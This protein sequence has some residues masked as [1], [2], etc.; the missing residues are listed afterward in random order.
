MENE[1]RIEDQISTDNSENQA[2]MGFVERCI[3]QPILPIVIST[4]ILLLGGFALMRLQIR[5]TP[6]VERGVFDIRVNTIN[7]M[8]AEEVEDQITKKLAKLLP[9]VPNLDYFQATS[10]SGE[11]RTT[12]HFK[13]GV[14]ESEALNDLRSVTSRAYLGSNA[15]APLIFSS[16]SDDAMMVLYFYP[17]ESEINDKNYFDNLQ[18]F[19]DNVFTSSLKK[20]DGVGNVEVFGHNKPN[21]NIELNFFK[22]SQLGIRPQEISMAINRE[23]SVST[24]ADIKTEIRSFTCTSRNRIKDVESLGEV[25]VDSKRNIKLKDVAKITIKNPEDS[26]IRLLNGKTKSIGVAI[27][28]TSEG[29]PIAI[30]KSVNHLLDN[31]VDRQKTQYVVRNSFEKSE[32]I[33]H[34]TKRT[35]VEAIILLLVILILFLG[36]VRIL[37]L[38]LVAI[39]LSV[40]GTF[41][42]MWYFNLSINEITLMAFLLTIGLL[43]DDAILIIENIERRR[44]K[45]GKLD[46]NVVYR[47]TMEIYKSVIVMTAT[48]F[49]VFLPVVFLPGEM[50]YLLREFAITISVSVGWSG[51]FS[52]ILT[53]MMCKYFMRNYHPYHW[54]ESFLEWLENSYR[55]FLLF[56][57]P[58][59]KFILTIVT[60]INMSGL[61][62]LFFINSEYYPKTKSDYFGI[63]TNGLRNMKTEYLRQIEGDKISQVVEKYLPHM[64]YYILDISGGEID[65]NG[66]FLKYQ[67]DIFGEKMKEDLQ[68]SIPYIN[69]M[70]YGSDDNNLYF[71]I[72]FSSQEES[73]VDE[74]AYEF[75]HLLNKTG[76]LKEYVF[77]QNSSYSY[78][79]EINRIKCANNRINPDDVR[80]YLDF[81][82]QSTRMTGK[83]LTKEGKRFRIV[84]KNAE[85]GDNIKTLLSYPWKVFNRRGQEQIVNLYDLVEIK[86]VVNQISV[87]TYNGLKSKRVR[88]LCEKNVTAG[89]IY[90]II[91]NLK[92]N[93]LSKEVYLDYTKDLKEYEQNSGKIIYV[94]IACLLSIFLILSVQFN[95][96]ISSAIVMLTVP[97]A[98]TGAVVILY[99]FGTINIFSMIGGI[100]LIAL[101][102][103]HGI[104]FMSKKG[105]VIALSVERLRPLLMTT[106]A[107]ILGSVPLLLYKEEAMVPLKQMAIVIVPGLFYGTLMVLVVFPI[108]LFLRRSN[109]K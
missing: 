86:P 56:L 53:P 3:K 63:Y 61:G 40:L 93:H 90:N 60:I 26:K 67:K 21:F 83:V 104:L 96:F 51:V 94:L 45:E 69:F 82:F 75:T 52:I 81:I 65:I 101:I 99:F 55:K 84:I 22:L 106:V 10:K 59:G 109:D 43:V 24:Y 87:D 30:V 23:T 5:N 38:P 2:N 98:F 9:S 66:E 6:K 72:I 31:L 1:D 4:F 29:N 89:E 71:D 57:L 88:I 8:G 76:K 70:S 36:S 14:S 79:I 35:F 62:L 42:F 97:L 107:M 37:L 91:Q 15:Q 64:R 100:T 103:K 33:F 74:A 108:I 92:K 17:S 50:G 77:I 80:S 68:K 20:I 7:P 102:T 18:N 85:L 54:T 25:I 39:P 34:K 16:S 41:M 46:E 47:A 28:K 48:L 13:A 73:M 49:C 27:Y 11:S 78:I 105:D 12:V 44:K 58:K 95:S 32:I 19:L